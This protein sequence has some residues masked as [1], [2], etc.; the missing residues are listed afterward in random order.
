MTIVSGSP[1]SHWVFGYGSLIWRP[2]FEF[3]T[4]HRAL[5]RGAHRSLC[6][7]SH[8]YRG[9]P[10][11][12][13]LVFGLVPGGSCCGMAFKI[14]PEKWTAVQAYL[15]EREQ[16][17]G[18]Y[19]EAVRPIEL[20]TGERVAALTF[21]VDEKHDQYA[22]RLDMDAQLHHVRHATGDMGP[23]VDYV[24]NTAQHLR[25]MNISDRHL[26]EMTRLLSMK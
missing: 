21:L 8:H 23:N 20:V 9:T 24:V 6:V 10:E 16:I 19:R 2:G 5:L 22:G 4:S 12:P 14:A 1:Q 26:E 17:T 7:Y 13:G 15:Q 3:V 18:V 25:E 11:N